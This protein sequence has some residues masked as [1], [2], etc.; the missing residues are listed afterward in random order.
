MRADLAKYIA[1]CEEGLSKVR[2]CVA[3]TSCCVV[4]VVS[5]ARQPPFLPV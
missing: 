5:V 3:A 2:F 4:Y 1:M